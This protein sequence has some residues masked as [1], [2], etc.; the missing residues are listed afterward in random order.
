MPGN[1]ADVSAAMLIKNAE[2]YTP[3]SFKK[4]HLLLAGGKIAD[5]LPP[6]AALPGDMPVYDADGKVVLPGAIDTHV[7]VREPGSPEKE[8]CLS[9]T[10][11][12]LAGGITTICQMPN[13]SPMPYNAETLAVTQKAAEK[14]L[15]NVAAYGAAGADNIAAYAALREA[16]VIGLKTF[17]QPGNPGEPQYITVSGNDGDKE[18]CALLAE[19]ARLNLRCFFHCEDY[20]LIGSLEQAAHNTGAE[21]YSFHYKTR[22]DQAEL[23]AVERVLSAAE[24][25]GAAVGIVHVSTV[26]A[27]EKIAAAKAA[28]QDVTMEIC[29]HHLF[30]DDS[31][32]NKFGPYAK[33]NPPLRSAE[34]VAGL[35]RFIAD[36]TA[37]YLG[38]DHAPHL[39]SQKQAGEEQIWLAP[40]GIAHIEIMLPL[41][42]TAVSEG[43][44]TLARLAELVS[45]NGYKVMGLYP[46]KG[47]IAVGAD[48]DLTIVD[49]HKKWRF[50]SGLMQTKA[51]EACRFLDGMELCGAV[52]AA[53]VRGRLLMAAGRVD[54]QSAGWGEFLTPKR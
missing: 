3:Q 25:T 42:L 11:A 7:H 44:L 31:Y 33:C 43:R 10:A 22:P 15:C 50:A 27:A 48:A 35:W 4:A 26:A 32:I 46:Q 41:L 13:V 36:G 47:R 34:D 28:G 45:V 30:F 52:E 14:A 38:S 21:D 9:G 53:F 40:S 20:G 6:D 37:D 18:L 1:S 19:A 51:R 5:I 24:K 17:L 29:F 23:N 54:Y 16:G 49:P 8:D 12:A 39:L 2:Y